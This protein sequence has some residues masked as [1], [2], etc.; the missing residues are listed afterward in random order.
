MMYSNGTLFI[1]GFVVVCAIVIRMWIFSDGTLLFQKKTKKQQRTYLDLMLVVMLLIFVVDIICKA[2][3]LL[4]ALLL[5][6]LAL[7]NIE[8]VSTKDL[9]RFFDNKK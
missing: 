1:V 7:Y 6:V 5:F 8:V 4:D 2:D 3:V 9:S